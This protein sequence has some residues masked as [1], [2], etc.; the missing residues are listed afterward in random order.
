MIEGREIEGGKINIG[1]IEIG[2]I[3]VTSG[4]NVIYFN[5]AEMKRPQITLYSMSINDEK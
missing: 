1:K 4:V 5:V 3:N 2:S